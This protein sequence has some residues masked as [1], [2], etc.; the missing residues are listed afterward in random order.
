M[1]LT[2]AT[3][4]FQAA[5]E[6]HRV[7]PENE[8]VWDELQQARLTVELLWVQHEATRALKP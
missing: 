1:N 2:E 5:L 7:D 6:A 3:R 4:H 8:P